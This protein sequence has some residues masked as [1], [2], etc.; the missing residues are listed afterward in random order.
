MIYYRYLDLDYKNSANK[1]LQYI[2]EHRPDLLKKDT[3]FWKDVDTYDVLTKI[4]E[5]PRMFESLNISIKFVAFF[6]SFDPI[7][8]IHIDTDC[9]KARINLPILNCEN[10]ETRFY[11][12]PKDSIQLTF[13]RNGVLYYKIDPAKCEWVD[14]FYLT[15][16]V[17]FRNNEPHNIVSNN[18][19][20]PRISCTIGFNEDISHL[21]N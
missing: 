15:Q 8:N 6:V 13:Q 11:T 16:P 14:Q 2:Q 20:T 10:T 4:P 5:L 3:S 1:L 12:A 9:A 18:P 21:L 19:L 7:I 17:V